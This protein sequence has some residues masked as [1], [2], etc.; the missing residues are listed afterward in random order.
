MTDP[1]GPRRER[2]LTP[3]FGAL[4]FG[5][6]VVTSLGAMWARRHSLP[7]NTGT[8]LLIGATSLSLFAQWQARRRRV[9]SK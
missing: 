7:Q 8:F 6:V 5:V 1:L 9:S 4:L 3:A 2:L